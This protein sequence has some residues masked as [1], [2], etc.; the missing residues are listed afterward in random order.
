MATEC[1]LVPA[2]SEM[3][4]AHSFPSFLLILS[5]IYA[6][7]FRVSSILRTFVLCQAC[8][9]PRPLSP[10]LL[11]IHPRPP[12]GNEPDDLD[13]CHCSTNTAVALQRARSGVSQSA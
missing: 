13:I 9:T 8:Y 7:N 1:Y 11:F 3:N 6:Y 2:L 4:S 10:L 5:R 12:S